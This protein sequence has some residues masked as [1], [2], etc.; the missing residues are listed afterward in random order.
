VKVG[1]EPELMN[2]RG[3]GVPSVVKGDEKRV[4]R[5][6]SVLGRGGGGWHEQ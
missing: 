1:D 4:G 2:G 6:S 5:P 3:V